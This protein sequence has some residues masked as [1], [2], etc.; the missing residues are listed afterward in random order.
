MTTYT[1]FA[2]GPYSTDATFRAWG[3]SVNA[4][5]V[6]SGLVQASD[7]GQ[8]NWT[9]VTKPVTNGA[10]VGYEI[11]RFNDS[12]QA[13]VPVFIKITYLSGGNGS[14]NNYCWSMVVG[15]GSNGSGT[16]TGTGSG[17]TLTVGSSLETTAFD[18]APWIKSCHT[19]GSWM[20]MMSGYAVSNAHFGSI[21]V[22]ISRTLNSSGTLTGEGLYIWSGT[23]TTSLPS[24]YQYSLN[25]NT[26]SAYGGVNA[27]PNSAM[28]VDVA[29]FNTGNA[30]YV[31]PHYACIPH[32]VTACGV[33][34]LTIPSL[35]G[36]NEATTF[37]LS[38][39]GGTARTY[40]LSY[41]RTGYTLLA[42]YQGN[43]LFGITS[44]SITNENSHISSAFLWE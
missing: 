27:S 38:L 29:S 28:P 40:L 13:T 31:F 30:I 23:S 11:Y 25:Y 22:S 44:A 43:S 36:P 7:T 4:A 34:N 12:L 16:I 14:G 3:T 33:V 9:T 19:S 20:F 2:A 39:N 6:G 32:P 41:Y 5:I 10:T 42:R 35:G 1:S 18:W 21:N 15:T 37:P 17:T 26:A 8:I 24:M